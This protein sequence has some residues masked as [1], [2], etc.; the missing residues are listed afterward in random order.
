MPRFCSCANFTHVKLCAML[1]VIGKS[2]LVNVI[3]SFLQTNG[4]INSSPLYDGSI[5][6]YKSQPI[7][8]IE[9]I[10]NIIIEAISIFFFVLHHLK[11]FDMYFYINIIFFH[12]PKIS[13]ETFISLL[14]SKHSCIINSIPFLLR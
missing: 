5:S 1:D 9:I 12:F 3:T 6:T 11:F 8:K 7:I 10:V 13:F 2:P 14:Q 4:I